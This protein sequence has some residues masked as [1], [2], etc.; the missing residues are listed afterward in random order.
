[1]MTTPTITQGPSM[2][3]QGHRSHRSRRGRLLA[4]G[5]AFGIVAGCVTGVS[6][7][8]WSTSTTPPAQ[9]ESFVALSGAQTPSKPMNLWSQS[10]G[11]NCTVTWGAN[12]TSPLTGAK[13]MDASGETLTTSGT[14]GGSYTTSG[15][16][17]SYS[18]AT[19]AD[20]FSSPVSS[21]R[22]VHCDQHGARVEQYG[23]VFATLIVGTTLYVG[24]SFQSVTVSGIEHIRS[25]LYAIDLSGATPTLASFN[26]ML[27]SPV[28]AL[29]SDGTYL[30]AGGE[31]TGVGCDSSYLYCTTR[32]E[33]AR[34]TLPGNTGTPSVD[35]FNPSLNDTVFS[36]ALGFNGSSPVHLYAGGRFTTVGGVTRNRV[37]RWTLDSSSLDTWNP[38]ADAPV[39]SIA[40]STSYVYLGGA[41][42]TIAGVATQPYA[43]RYSRGG[44]ATDTLTA[45]TA[46]SVMYASGA[47]LVGAGAVNTVA[48]NGSYVYLGGEF[49][50]VTST[51]GASATRNR[52]ARFTDGAG[53]TL[54]AWNPNLNGSVQQIVLSGSDVYA[55]GD[56]TSAAGNTRNHISR[57]QPTT[58]SPWGIQTTA[59]SIGLGTVLPGTLNPTAFSLS[60][61]TVNGVSQAVVG[62]AFGAVAGT[63]G[64]SLG[65]FKV[66]DATA[67]ALQHSLTKPGSIGA[68]AALLSDGTLY[69]GG[70]FSLLNGEP[71]GNLGAVAVE[72]AALAGADASGVLPF[73]PAVTGVA[74]GFTPDPWNVYD[75]FLKLSKDNDFTRVNSIVSDGT[76]LWAGGFFFYAGV[77]AQGVDPTSSRKFLAA[78]SLASPA[79]NQPTIKGAF[80]T[81]F[82]WE[83]LDLAICP[84]SCLGSSGAALVAVGQFSAWGATARSCVAV[85]SKTGT[86]EAAAPNIGGCSFVSGGSV[87]SV[88]GAYSISGFVGGYQ[89][90]IGGAFTSVDGDTTKQDVATFWNAPAT[91]GTYPGPTALSVTPTATGLLW[92]AD[93]SVFDLAFYGTC[94]Y[95]GGDFTSIG[96]A[97]VKGLARG[98]NSG[99]LSLPAVVTSIDTGFAP[100][101]NYDTT[102]GGARGLSVAGENVYT[103][104]QLG[105]VQRTAT[106]GVVDAW[107]PSI[108]FLYTTWSLMYASSL[109]DGTV[110]A[111]AETNRSPWGGRSG[112]AWL[113]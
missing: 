72:G 96:G 91:A 10:D 102:W 50:K 20:A 32:N 90:A 23:Q 84:A 35:A 51:A 68:H 95:I 107:S 97:N 64:I 82:D 105:G 24:G 113:G 93:A 87:R 8:E 29:A 83:V 73:N 56:F 66:S 110:L 17:T 27:N 98:C 44:G 103:R 39:R 9:T 11:G 78:W 28:H 80:T 37:A 52:L 89:V 92:N 25:N 14:G 59:P 58:S 31:F 7:A 22:S 101:L 108:G 65:S 111:L 53:R 12:N 106:T 45:D 49:T 47:L 109:T 60:L 99:V 13:L 40:V 42:T 69:L 3:R 88:D 100:Q 33:L 86:L 21:N 4:A 2:A 16:T 43:A 46:W 77:P 74:G 1:M 79:Y 67:G 57:W 75:E 5:L 104:S 70:T 18:L 62:G 54:N 6:S 63:D 76:T 71:R 85:F 15:A 61:V 38:N 26:P 48:A 94:L 112:L 41:F 30:Y 34:W 81:G 36:L 55:V 19:T